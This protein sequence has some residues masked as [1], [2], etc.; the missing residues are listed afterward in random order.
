ME[1]LYFGTGGVPHSSKDPSSISGIERI[2]ELKLGAMELEFVQRVTMGEAGA[3]LVADVAK[4]LDV[5]LSVHAPYY[6]NLNA[7]EPEKLKASQ[8]RLLQAAHIGW[9]CG[10]RSV[11]FHPGFYLGDSPEQA[12][13]IIKDNLAVVVNQLRREGNKI[14]VRPEVMG[15]PSQFGTIDEVLQLSLE[16]DGVAPCVDFAHWHA[17]TGVSNSYV[18]FVSTLEAI[19]K[20]LGRPALDDIHIHVSGIHYGAKGELNH[21]NIP[22]SDFNY[23]DFLRALKDRK[24]KGLVIC[25]SPNL[26]GDAQLL[27]STYNSL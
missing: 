16:L 5:K 8:A 14:I 21:L 19:E 23:R 13:A 12:Y 27:Q 10:A 20:R 6:I 15:K 7:R 9:L 25:E 26:E 17:R 22:D 24:V 1:Q 4:R 3:R 2:A 11:V 18:E